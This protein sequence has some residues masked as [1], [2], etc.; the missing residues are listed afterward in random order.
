MI[1]IQLGSF[2]PPN[3]IVNC[4]TK[5]KCQTVFL[6]CEGVNPILHVKNMLELHLNPNNYN[7]ITFSLYSLHCLTLP[8][9]L[10]LP[11]SPSYLSFLVGVRQINVKAGFTYHT[12]GSTTLQGILWKQ[13]ASQ[14]NTGHEKTQYYY[15]YTKHTYLLYIDT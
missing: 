1:R 9:P 8:L 11:L 10:P 15:N 2:P 14:F 3:L 13:T 4:P 7:N 5:P 6:K 12:V